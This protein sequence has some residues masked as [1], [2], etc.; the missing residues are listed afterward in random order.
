[1]PLASN[2]RLEIAVFQQIV[3]F[4]SFGDAKPECK[5]DLFIAYLIEEWGILEDDFDMDE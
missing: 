1:M 2:L 4:R 3:H 5:Q